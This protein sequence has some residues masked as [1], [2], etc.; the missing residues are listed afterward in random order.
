MILP[1]DDLDAIHRRAVT[2]GLRYSTASAETP[3]GRS[4]LASRD[5]DGD[6]RSLARPSR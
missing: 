3:T 4:R 1:M 2:E 6:G 5:L